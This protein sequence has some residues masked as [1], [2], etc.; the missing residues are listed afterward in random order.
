MGSG[1]DGS[2]VFKAPAGP[3][4]V[5]LAPARLGGAETCM[6]SCTEW[7]FPSGCLLSGVLP[8]PWFAG[9]F[10]WFSGQK[11]KVSYR[12]L[13]AVRT[14]PPCRSGSG[15]KPGP[16]KGKQTRKLALKQTVSAPPT[17]FDSSDSHPLLFT[18]E[19]SGSCF[20]VVVF[21]PGLCIVISRR[22]RGCFK[23]LTL[24]MPEELPWN[25]L[26]IM[27]SIFPPAVLLRALCQW[28]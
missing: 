24:T 20:Q 12:V 7:G 8:T 19:S 9:S 18:F 5:C 10:S 26:L 17:G 16:Q 25:I 15:A 28:I 27:A 2:V 6:G 11:H 23:R 1:S 13:P 3:L 4:R 22:E 14:A 21:P